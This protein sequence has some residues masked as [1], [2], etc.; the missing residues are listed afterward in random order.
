[1]SDEKS[2]SSM[3]GRIACLV[4]EFCGPEDTTL[5]GVAILLARYSDLRAKQAWDFVD[6]LKEEEE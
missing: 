1:M 5:Q 2:H 4:E 6:Q 3:L